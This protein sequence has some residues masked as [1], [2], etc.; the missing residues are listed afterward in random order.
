MTNS[1][2]FPPCRWNK[3]VPVLVVHHQQDGCPYCASSEIPNPDGQAD[4]TPRSHPIG[5][6]GGKEPGSACAAFAH[7]GFNGLRLTWWGKWPTGILAPG[8]VGMSCI[9]LA[10]RWL[11]RIGI[12]CKAQPQLGY[13]QEK[14]TQRTARGRAI[15][16]AGDG[17]IMDLL[18][19][20]SRG[21][22]SPIHA[23]WRYASNAGSKAMS[24]ITRTAAARKASGEL[25]PTDEG[26]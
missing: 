19:T 10:S 6:T 15:T 25:W 23:G 2:R 18:R 7:H 13:W 14:A 8:P 12:G 9:T 3:S 1:A 20:S 24:A 16:T 22:P 4:H 26:L 11:A 21:A 5:A 17:D